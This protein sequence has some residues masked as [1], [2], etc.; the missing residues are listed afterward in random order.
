MKTLIILCVT[1]SFVLAQAP[2]DKQ[3]NLAAGIGIGVGNS[4]YKGADE[5]IIPVP[6]IYYNYRDFFLA[7]T[8]A[9]YKF[10]NENDLELAVIAQWRTEGYDES[11]SR[12]LK[13]MDD[14]DM[15]VDGGLSA[16]Y[17]DG[18]GKTTLS[19]LTDMLGKHD[20]QEVS[21]SYGKRLQYGDF[22]LTP[23]AGLSYRNNN[24][25]DYY[26]GVM[27]K[28]ATPARAAYNSGESYNPFIKLRM[29]YD[30]GSRWTAMGIAGYEF[31]GNEITN[32]TIVDDNYLISFIAGLAYNF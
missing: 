4:V 8:T 25:N 9:G 16:S 19:F 5:R 22:S 23:S 30:L 7:G 14:R 24:L 15:T 6:L 10:Y 32:S 1:A 26:Y 2:N 12:H 20:G 31:L 18:W 28:E 3:S 27:T 29:Q 11:D 13:D 17:K 21:L